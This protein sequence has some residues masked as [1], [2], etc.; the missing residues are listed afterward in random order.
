[1]PKRKVERTCVICGKRF[2]TRHDGKTCSRSCASRYRYSKT[3]DQRLIM[4]KKQLAKLGHMEYVSGFTSTRGNIIV[5]CPDTGAVFRINCSDMRHGK[6][7]CIC[8]RRKTDSRTAIYIPPK[9][10]YKAHV[11]QY[12]KIITI[13]VKHELGSAIH[14]HASRCKQCGKLTLNVRKI[15]Y[16]SDACRKRHEHIRKDKRLKRAKLNGRY[17]TITLERL[18]KRDKGVCYLCGKHLVL[19]DDYNRLEAPTIEH[20]IPICDGGTNTWD[21]VKLACR[22]CNNHKGTSRIELKNNQMSFLLV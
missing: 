6:L 11:S 10:P 12:N 4:L 18:Y 2:M 1:M 15:S 20:V 3:T 9:K 13:I 8:A 22:N 17:E 21:N 19:N 14:Y 16:C 5:R 7:P